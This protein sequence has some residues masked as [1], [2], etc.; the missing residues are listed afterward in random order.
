MWVKVCGVRDRETALRL[1]EIGVDAI[2]LNF[3]AR[4]PRMI[5][6]EEAVEISRV[7][8]GH[9]ERVGVFVNH[10]L[11]ELVSIADRCRLD[12]VQ[13]HG[14]EPTSYLF[15][16]RNRL[17]QMRLIRAVR[18]GEDGLASLSRLL[19]ECEQQN[20]ELA[21]CL[22][23]AHVAG[24]YGGSGKTVS[25][26][27]L[28]AEYQTDQWPPL[29]LAGGLTEKNVAEAIASTRPWGVDTASGVESSPGIKDPER[30]RQFVTN[31]KSA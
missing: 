1:A 20:C 6:V 29:I 4:S 31:A 23:D 25:W 28:K 24:V 9:V 10:D 5:A 27:R 2:G 12:A 16:L 15:E 22:V 7:L 13:L 18:M 21:G 11:K 19:Q 17:P 26:E 8:P 30:A 3:Y 14:D